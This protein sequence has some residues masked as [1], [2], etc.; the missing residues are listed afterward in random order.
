MPILKEGERENLFF[1]FPPKSPEFFPKVVILDLLDLTFQ[2]LPFVA[3]DEN[4]VE[5]Q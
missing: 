4:K 2:V 1:F 5:N 3:R